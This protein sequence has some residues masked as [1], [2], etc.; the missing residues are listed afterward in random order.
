MHWAAYLRANKALYALIE[1]GAS[2]TVQDKVCVW[3]L[4]ATRAAARALPD[5]L[6]RR[7]RAPRAGISRLQ[8]GA[9]VELLESAVSCCQ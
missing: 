9:R 3:H 8:R 1:A 4:L 2:C 7:T 5:P 6:Q